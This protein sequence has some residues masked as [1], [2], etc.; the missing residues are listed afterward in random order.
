MTKILVVDDESN[1]IEL[2]KL[3]LERDGYQ[4]EGV[5]TGQDALSKQSAAKPDLILT[6]TTKLGMFQAVTDI[7]PDIRVESLRID[8]FDD[9]LVAISRIGELTG[10]PAAAGRAAGRMTAAI[11]SVRKSVA[12]KGRPRVVFAMGLEH[13]AVMAAGSFQHDMIEIAGGSNAGEE[14]SGI[15]PWRNTSLKAI[16]AAIVDYAAKDPTVHIKCR[17]DERAAW[18]FA[19]ESFQFRD[20]ERVPVFGIHF[21]DY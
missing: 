14:V 18:T 19:A 3:Y 8:K 20:V 13:P 15:G 17:C 4:V 2:A 6:Q 12:G 10:K 16:I 7:N 1:I 9:I 5:A 11:D 21:M